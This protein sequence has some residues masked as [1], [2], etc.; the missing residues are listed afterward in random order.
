MNW[1]Y[2]EADPNV[3]APG[4]AC[5]SSFD[6]SGKRPAATLARQAIQNSVYA[7][8]DPDGAVRVGRSYRDD[9]S[10]RIPAGPDQEKHAPGEE[11]SDP[12]SLCRG[13][14]NGRRTC[15]NF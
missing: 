7:A 8:N 1:H 2:E 3:G 12:A 5:K 11:E 9:E 14:R 4:D 15:E 10:E 6:G 13:L